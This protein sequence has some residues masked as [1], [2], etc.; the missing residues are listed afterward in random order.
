MKLYKQL[1]K[2]QSGDKKAISDIYLRFYLNIKKWSK[3][4]NYEEGETDITIEL[5]KL[6]K[7]I[8]IER[9]RKDD[10]YIENFIYTFIKNKSIDLLKK[11]NSRKREDLSIDYDILHDT[12]IPSFES[13]P[14]ILSLVNTL[15]KKQRVV[16]VEKFIH[17]HKVND[18]AKKLGISRQA[19]HSLERRGLENLKTTLM[20]WGE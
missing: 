2:G 14:F 4:L 7:N 17:Q 15:S 10:D 18:I 9:F 19:V 1:K 6:I 5:L 3:K 16:I 11:N 13:R 20:N 8:D 12:R